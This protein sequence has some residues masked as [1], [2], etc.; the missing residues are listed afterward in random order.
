MLAA[1]HQSRRELAHMLPPRQRGARYRCSPPS[2]WGSAK[3]GPETTPRHAVG[4]VRRKVP[5]RL[6]EGLSRV[7]RARLRAAVRDLVFSLRGYQSLSA[8]ISLYR[9][10]LCISQPWGDLYGPHFHFPLQPEQC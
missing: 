10:S 9:D 3:T 2:T 7:S 8:F 5:R 6:R 4:R 1:L